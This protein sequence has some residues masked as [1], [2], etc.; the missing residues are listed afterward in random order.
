MIIRTQKFQLESTRMGEMRE[1]DDA[2]AMRT[3]RHDEWQY[4]TDLMYI[5]IS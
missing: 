1:E 2:G 3:V 5:N 4:Y